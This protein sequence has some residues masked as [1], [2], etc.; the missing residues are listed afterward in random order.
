[1]ELKK[2]IGLRCLVKWAPAVYIRL[3]SQIK[4]LQNQMMCFEKKRWIPYR[5]LLLEEQERK[6]YRCKNLQDVHYNVIYFVY[7]KSFL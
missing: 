4:K 2:I 6:K 7:Y 3:K 5:K 1:M